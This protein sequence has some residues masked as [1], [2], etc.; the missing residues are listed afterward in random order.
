MKELLPWFHL[1]DVSGIGNLLC[2]RL[3]DRFGSPESV[4]A[5][6]REALSQVGGMR[7][8]QIC[9]LKSYRPADWIPRELSR[10]REKGYGIIPLTHPAY[11][12]LLREIPDPPPFLYVFGR[13]ENLLR[14]LSVVGS[15]HATEYGISTTKRLC[16]TLAQLGMTIVS[17]MARGIDTAAHIGALLGNGKT[18]AVLGS[19]F[20]HIY[21]YENRD[22]FYTIARNGAV[23]SEFPLR[24]EPDPHNFPTRNRIISGMSLGTVVVEA[25]Q[26]SG[27]LITAR[28]AAE[29]NREVFAV[30]GNVHSFKSIGTHRLIKQG[31]KLVENA[32][33]ILEEL[34][35]ESIPRQAPGPVP[36]QKILPTLS[37]EESTVLEVLEPYPIQIDELVRKTGTAPGKLAGIL[38]GLEIKGLVDQMP[39]KRF[40][41]TN[42]RDG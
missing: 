24:T 28:L 38:L 39:G 3:I 10:I 25:T 26:K 16:E 17:G 23:V 30:P 14:P 4:F 42:Q 11:P 34:P 33:D 8:A 22:L 35:P 27:S 21:P 20:D 13:L 7:R 9:A 31:A 40:C 29:Q 2:K 18:I 5:A 12:P 36:R 15:R 6:S 41:L 37:R 1:K 19:G 32:Q